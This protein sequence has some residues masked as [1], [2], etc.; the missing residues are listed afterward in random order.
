MQ[1]IQSTKTEIIVNIAD[2]DYPK[3]NL[4]NFNRNRNRKILIQLH[5][6]GFIKVFSF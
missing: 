4:Y 2:Y 5:I 1:S 3:I 6:S